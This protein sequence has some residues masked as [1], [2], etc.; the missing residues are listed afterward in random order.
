MSVYGF[1]G[2]QDAQQQ[3]DLLFDAAFDYSSRFG[4]LPIFIGMDANTDTIS[5]QSL[6]QTCENCCLSWKV[7]AFQCL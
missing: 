6:S 4:N 3:N 7:K 1:T 5:S 2:H